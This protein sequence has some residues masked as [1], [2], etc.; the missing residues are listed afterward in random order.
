MDH[1]YDIE[2]LRMSDG[3]VASP[4]SWCETNHMAVRRSGAEL[5]CR[6]HCLFLAWM[7]SRESPNRGCLFSLV[8]V[9][10][11]PNIPWHS[12]SSGVGAHRSPH[13]GL[14]SLTYRFQ[15]EAVE[16]TRV[17]LPSSLSIPLLF[18]LS[19]PGKLNN[20]SITFLCRILQ[21]FVLSREIVLRWWESPSQW[22]TS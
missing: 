2:K 4:D 17:E 16:G 18:I 6:G 12:T 20:P 13:T 11:I 21:F 1:R 3:I 19:S 5:P 8:Q 9:G 10:S 7:K 15:Y 14:R 22:R